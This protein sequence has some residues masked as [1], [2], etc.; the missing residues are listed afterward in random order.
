MSDDLEFVIAE[1]V[2]RFSQADPEEAEEAERR[3]RRLIARARAEYR[4]AGA[5]YGDT[6]AGFVMWMEPMGSI[7]PSA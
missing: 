7:T 6:I 1:L 2:S 3:I 4:A 5:P